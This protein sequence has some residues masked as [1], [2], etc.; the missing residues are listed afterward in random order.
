MRAF[1]GRQ[2]VPFLWW[3]LVWPGVEANSRPTVREA[4]KLP[5]EPTWHG[6]KSKQQHLLLTLTLVF[7][8]CKITK[9]QSSCQTFI[10]CQCH[11]C[12]SDCMMKEC[13]YCDVTLIIPA[14][15]E[16]KKGIMCYR[17]PSVRPS[18][19]KQ[20]T[21]ISSY[22][23]D[24]RITKPICMIP[25]CIQ[26]VA[27]YLKFFYIFQFWYNS[28]FSDFTQKCN[29]SVNFS[30]NWFKFFKCMGESHIHHI[31][32]RFYHVTSRSSLKMEI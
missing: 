5:T 20:F 16:E 17:S 24:A 31:S 21:S 23:I 25:L 30:R 8:R 22:T 3:S 9:F 15:F 14:F 32:N 10:L 2:F 29:F 6:W 28:D 18:V 1:A 7:R 4:D 11:W 26:M 19:R 27:T 12:D 13:C